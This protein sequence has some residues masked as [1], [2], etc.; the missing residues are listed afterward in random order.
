MRRRLKSRQPAESSTR[1][2]PSLGSI[3]ADEVLRLAEFGR[4]MGMGSRALADVQ[5]A[6]LRTHKYGKWLFVTGRDALEWFQSLPD[7]QPGGRKANSNGKTDTAA[8]ACCSNCCQ[9]GQEGA[10]E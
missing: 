2:T 8:P 5:R 10:R 4:R 3:R 7:S 9:R 1:P 6:G